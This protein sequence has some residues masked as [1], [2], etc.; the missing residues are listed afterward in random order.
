MVNKYKLSAPVQQNGFVAYTLHEWVDGI[1]NSYRAEPTATIHVRASD[2]GGEAY[3]IAT[4]VPV[5][6][7]ALNLEHALA[8]LKSILS[9]TDLDHQP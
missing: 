9:I 3:V 8:F 4:G 6:L 7:K 1:F 5:G 2:I